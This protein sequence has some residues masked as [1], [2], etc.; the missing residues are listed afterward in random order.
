MPYVINPVSRVKMVRYIKSDGKLETK[1]GSSAMEIQ[2]D[3]FGKKGFKF[4]YI[5]NCLT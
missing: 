1:E 4:G 5:K 2:I 3:N